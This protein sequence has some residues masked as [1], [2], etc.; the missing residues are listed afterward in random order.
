MTE[1]SSGSIKRIRRNVGNSR[2]NDHPTPS[3][4]TGSNSISTET[5]AFS[6]LRPQQKCNPWVKF[7]ESLLPWKMLYHISA[8]AVSTTAD[9]KPLP[10][11]Y[12]TLDEYATSWT[13]ALNTEIKAS[14]VGNLDPPKL[15]ESCFFVE[16]TEVNERDTGSSDL[17]KLSCRPRAGSA[18]ASSSDSNNNFPEKN[19]YVWNF[20]VFNC[21]KMYECSFSG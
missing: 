7:G 17:V 9:Y 8:D 6:G 20:V 16:L 10:L 21:T 2:S 19:R 13:T 4:C 5:K 14:V 1:T 18:P 3:N 12:K 11:L 15:I